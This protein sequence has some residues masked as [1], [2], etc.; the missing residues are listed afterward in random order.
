MEDNKAPVSSS[1]GKS[2]SKAPWWITI[3][4]AFV[5][6]VGLFIKSIVN[7]NSQNLKDVITSQ[8]KYIESL[9]TALNR[10]TD[11]LQQVLNDKRNESLNTYNIDS[12]N[13]F[14]PNKTT[15]AGEANKPRPPP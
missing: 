14:Y 7:E 9:T 4:V 3:V 1:N 8:G 10:S 12:I 2:E 13:V 11:V 6:A 5:S 15:N